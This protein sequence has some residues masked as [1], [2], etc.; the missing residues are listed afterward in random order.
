MTFFFFPSLNR[1]ASDL[2][3]AKRNPRLPQREKDPLALV[4]RCLVRPQK[5]ARD[6]P[7][8]VCFL[9]G[10][11]DEENV[12]VK[13]NATRQQAESKPPV[14]S[15]PRAPSAPAAKVIRYEFYFTNLL[16]PVRANNHRQRNQR[17]QRARDA[18][19][20]PAR[21][22]S[23][24]IGHSNHLCFTALIVPFRPETD[25]GATSTSATSSEDAPP[26]ADV[27]PSIDDTPLPRR[28]RGMIFRKGSNSSH[29]V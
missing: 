1:R 7:L 13:G 27:P 18:P 23:A 3:P 28:Y 5:V 20:R 8:S 16:I 17:V 19:R 24:P 4:R 22:Q 2:G 10:A 6:N 26:E 15:N 14:R 29:L 12:S 9:I 21:T 11:G 25:A